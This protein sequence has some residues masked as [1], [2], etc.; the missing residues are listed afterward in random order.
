MED[1]NTGI[2]FLYCFRRFKTRVL[3]EYINFSSSYFNL[4]PLVS[5]FKRRKQRWKFPEHGI[6]IPTAGWEGLLH[7]EAHPS[8]LTTGCLEQSAYT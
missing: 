8:P 3:G 1:N 2:Q 7:G 5:Y 6:Q 4:R